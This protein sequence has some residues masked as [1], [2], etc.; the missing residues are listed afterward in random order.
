MSDTAQ[1]T[2][3][4]PDREPDDSAARTAGDLVYSGL[5]ARILGHEFKLGTPLR[6]DEVASWFN[7]SRVPARDSLRKLEQEGLVER[8]G[9][10]YQIRQFS[11]DEVIIIYRQRAALEFLAVD[12]AV[13]AR[14]RQDAAT[15]L[16]AVAAVL[17]QQR[18]VLGH[19]SRAEFSRLDKAFH[20]EIARVSGQPLL[21]RELE[22]ILNRV[23]L[24]RTAELEH[25]AGPTGAFHDHCRIFGALER[26][27]AATARS[28]LD[29]HYATTVRLHTR[30]V[31]SDSP[32]QEKP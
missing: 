20:L 19:A 13:Q 8:S 32:S 15:A 14:A 27:D 1:M 17:D 23:Q 4:S 22:I 9:R 7:T 16:G 25:D 3:P 29:Y 26:G 10:R 24:I 2:P 31:A 12:Y 28:E 6:E 11:Y 18:Q 5:K 21:L 30:A